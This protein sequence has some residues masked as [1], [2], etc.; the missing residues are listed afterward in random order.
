MFRTIGRKAYIGNPSLCIRYPIVRGIIKSNREI[1]THTWFCPHQSIEFVATWSCILA[2]TMPERQ[3]RMTHRQ[4]RLTTA[5]NSYWNITQQVWMYYRSGTGRHTEIQLNQ[6]T[7]IYLKN[8][9]AKFHP[10]PIWNNRDLCCIQ[11]GS[12]TRT[13]EFP[14]RKYSSV[15]VRSRISKWET[16]NSA[17]NPTSDSEIRVGKYDF[18]SPM[19]RSI[20]LFCLRNKKQEAQ[21]PQ[22]DSASATHVFLGS[23]TDH[24]LHWAPHMF[25]KYIIDQL[26][27]YRHY[28]PTNHATYAL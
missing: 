13:C 5:W 7:C 27:S 20:S 14:S 11:L 23:L 25:Y 6:S 19:E 22:R 16:R 8:I 12:E 24:P 2:P 18:P 15:E 4:T 28:Q 3:P 26:N 21:L 9:P 17:S 10:Y 1:W